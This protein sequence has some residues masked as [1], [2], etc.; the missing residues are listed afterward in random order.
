MHTLDLR[1]LRFKFLNYR[2]LYWIYRGI[3]VLTSE[4]SYDSFGFS[5]YKLTPQLISLT[6][7]QMIEFHFLHWEIQV[8][9]SHAK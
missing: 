4:R 3:R 8:F 1:L 6:S 5:F 2:P 9:S 7:L